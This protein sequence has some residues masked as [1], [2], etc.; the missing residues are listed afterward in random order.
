MEKVPQLYGLNPMHLKSSKKKKRCVYTLLKF[1]IM[2]YIHEINNFFYIPIN[3]S[4]T[5]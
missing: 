2:G 1:I 5:A 3:S 4:L